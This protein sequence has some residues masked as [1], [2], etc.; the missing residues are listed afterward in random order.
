MRCSGG[1][2]C[3]G[4]LRFVSALLFAPRGPGP[5]MVQALGTGWYRYSRDPR[6][7]VVLAESQPGGG[8]GLDGIRCDSSRRGVR[9]RFPPPPPFIYCN[10]GT[11]D[12]GHHPRCH[13]VAMVQQL[14]RIAPDVGRQMRVAHRHLDRRVSHQLLHRLERHAPHHQMRGEGVPQDVPAD[15]PQARALART[16]DGVHCRVTAPSRA[17]PSCTRSRSASRS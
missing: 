1:G 17:A 4:A 16:P 6:R 8:T 15:R 2:K 3:R 12:P 11:L 9:V 13:G 10:S 14:D 7:C 5:G